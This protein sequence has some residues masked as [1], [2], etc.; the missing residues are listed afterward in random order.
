M[1]RQDEKE[2]ESDKAT[3]PEDLL[4][5]AQ[6]LEPEGTGSVTLV[7][8]GLVGEYKHGLEGVQTVTKR[9]YKFS[10]ADAAKIMGQPGAA[11]YVTEVKE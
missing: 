11:L 4:P 8:R 5:S 2:R 9:P 1:A 3:P 10:K 6:K 7:T